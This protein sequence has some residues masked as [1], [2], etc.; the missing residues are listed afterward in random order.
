MHSAS[1]PVVPALDATGVLSRPFPFTGDQVGS[2]TPSLATTAAPSPATSRHVDVVVPLKAPGPDE[3]DQLPPRKTLRRRSRS[4]SRSS[5]DGGD[6]SDGVV[7][8]P[9]V[10]R[11]KTAA[12]NATATAPDSGDTPARSTRSKAKARPVVRPRA[13]VSSPRSV[14]EPSKLEP[15]RDL[16]HSGQAVTTPRK[17]IETMSQLVQRTP[18]DDEPAGGHDDPQPDYDTGLTGSGGLLGAIADD[19]EVPS[20]QVG[21]PAAVATDAHSPALADAAV[22]SVTH[23]SP[24]RVAAEILPEPVAAA[25]SSDGEEPDHQLLVQL[26]DML[27]KLG[28]KRK[29]KIETVKLATAQV[30]RAVEQQRRSDAMDVDMS[31][32]RASGRIELIV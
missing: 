14:V 17:P 4:A 20:V 29:G 28:T 31:G 13:I 10:K 21:A 15:V 16:Q 12:S 23:N 8:R 18:I 30:A 7:A 32:S 3:F 1:Q 26:Q 11:R 5:A 19:A 25:E 24:P 27:A 9:A 2:P 22:M 6:E